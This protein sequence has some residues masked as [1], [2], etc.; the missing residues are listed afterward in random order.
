MSQ[1]VA[2]LELNKLVNGAF[3]PEDSKML[4]LH[5]TSK[6]TGNKTLSFRD[7]VG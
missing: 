2:Y 4:H 3:T 1:C 6:V 5:R 7:V